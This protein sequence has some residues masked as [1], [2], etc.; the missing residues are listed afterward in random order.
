MVFF[1]ASVCM[2]RL[3]S[4]SV[5]ALCTVLRSVVMLVTVACRAAMSSLDFLDDSPL[6]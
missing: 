1:C 6:A 2:V 3:W 4:S 5:R